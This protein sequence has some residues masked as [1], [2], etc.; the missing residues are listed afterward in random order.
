MTHVLLEM[1]DE[2]TARR[3]LNASMLLYHW[4]LRP[5]SPNAFFSLCGIYHLSDNFSAPEMAELD[6]LASACPLREGFI[7]T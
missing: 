2:H 1:S 5:N 3:L 4:T 6:R 7:E